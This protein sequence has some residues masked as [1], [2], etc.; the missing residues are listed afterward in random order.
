[1]NDLFMKCVTCCSMSFK[2]LRVSFN[3]LLGLYI[4]IGGCFDIRLC[5]SLDLLAQ[6]HVTIL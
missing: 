5:L 4:Y 2:S 3:T 1:M 6:K